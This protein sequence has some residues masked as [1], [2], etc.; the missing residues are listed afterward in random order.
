MKE[1]IH[2]RL[3]ASLAEAVRTYAHGRGI[4]LA[5]AVSVLLAKAL[6]GGSND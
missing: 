4:S 6:K 2:I 1:D 5:A 3:D